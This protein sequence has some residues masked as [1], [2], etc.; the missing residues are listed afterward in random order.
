LS[1]TEFEYSDLEIPENAL[2]NED[3]PIHIKITNTGIFHGD[4]VVQLY[5]KHLNSPY[6]VPIHALQGFKR[7]HL[8][9]GEQKTI[10]FTLSPRQL[11]II[12]DN[13][14]RVVI[15]GRIQIFVGGQQPN[16][17]NI[18]EGKVLKTEIQLTG[19]SNV[20]DK[21]DLFK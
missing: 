18:T 10:A 11:S 20:I 1:F 13:N 15:P 4:E 19:K 3:I 14:Q 5:V 21:L 7:V 9:A 17:K 2:T 16:E 12:D 8:K 6:P